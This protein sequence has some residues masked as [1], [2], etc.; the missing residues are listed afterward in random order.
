MGANFR[1]ILRVTGQIFS[2]TLFLIEQ[3]PDEARNCEAGWM[4]DYLLKVLASGK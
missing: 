3:P 1:A 2:T 4:E